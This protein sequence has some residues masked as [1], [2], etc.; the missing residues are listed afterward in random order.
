MAA[1]APWL[2]LPAPHRALVYAGI[3]TRAVAFAA[4]VA[5]V[6]AVA[7]AATVGVGL[8]LAAVL[9]GPLSADLAGILAT[10][11]GWALLWG[12]Y[13]AGFWV[14]VGQTPGMRL[15]GIAVCTPDGGRV[16]PVRGLVRLAGF[17]LAIL[18]CF[19]GFAPIV[20]DARRRGLHDW[21]AGTVVIRVPGR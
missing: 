11:A 20:V 16:A 17:G 4:D 21:L 2:P 15:M 14:L 6:V 12:A 3:V 9:P 18:P 5:L 7:L 1:T 8:V 10:T 13:L 19:L